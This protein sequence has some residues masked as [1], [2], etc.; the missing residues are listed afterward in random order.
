MPE[1][2]DERYVRELFAELYGVG[3]RKVPESNST[4]SCCPKSGASLPLR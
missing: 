3:L 2:D 1:L 4:T